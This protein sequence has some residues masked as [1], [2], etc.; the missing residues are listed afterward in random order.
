MEIIGTGLIAS[1]FKSSSENIDNSGW[2]I[3]ASGV[4]N[5]QE[6]NLESFS[7]EI[8]LLKSLPKNKR[9]V[10]FSTCSVSVSPEYHSKYIEHK[11]KIENSLDERKDLIIR[12]PNVVGKNGNNKN[13]INFF[14]NS[15]IDN[16]DI[17]I[18]KD[19]KRNLIGIAE[20][21]KIVN[22]LIKNKC[23]GIYEVGDLSSYTIKEIVE[24]IVDILGI[25]ANVKFKSGGYSIPVDLRKIIQAIPN[26][27]NFF[28]SGYMRKT[29][30]KKIKGY[31]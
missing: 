19:S 22:K 7:R 3:Y 26:Y 15:I 20:V 23:S 8:K 4:S 5:S 21:V 11:I 10:Y 31:I 30:D 28:E 25:E 9:I 17:V 29:L 14:I 24:T 12:L 27:N 2:I 18:Q 6:N 1:G 16:K 13:I